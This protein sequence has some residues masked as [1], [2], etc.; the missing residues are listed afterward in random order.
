ML[1]GT[2]LR[3]FTYYEDIVDGIIAAGEKGKGDGYPLGAEE[4][5]TL[6]QVGEMFGFTSAENF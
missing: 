1:P 3:T 6:W 2:Q 4:V 5:Y